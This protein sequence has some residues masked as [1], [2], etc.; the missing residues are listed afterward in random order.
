MQDFY[1]E[2]IKKENLFFRNLKLGSS[3]SEVESI[4]GTK[5]LKKKGS[6]PSLYYNWETGKIE[7]IDL[8]FGVDTDE[9]V[10]RVKLMF[11][12][13]PDFYHEEKT[14]EDFAA[15]E[16]R[17]YA[18]NIEES[19]IVPN[20]LLKRILTMF[21]NK[22]G[23]PLEEHKDEIFKKSYHNFKRWIWFKEDDGIPLRLSLTSYLD[24]SDG[25]SIKWTL[26]ILL[27]ENIII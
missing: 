19:L 7:T 6:N 4:E 16:K 9:K 2:I 1:H 10:N 22:L 15:F 12:T 23:V 20:N 18:N 3:I 25:S 13:E 27:S 5:Y 24:D 14:G 8:Y 26:S 11:Y 17:F 21:S